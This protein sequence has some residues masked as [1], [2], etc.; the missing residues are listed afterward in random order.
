MASCSV[1]SR[2]V[3]RVRVYC[4][5]R[6][7]SPAA[8][9]RPD[10]V[11]RSQGRRTSGHTPPRGRA[12]WRGGRSNPSRAGHG[13]AVGTR[14]RAPYDRH[15]LATRR[16]TEVGTARPASLDP[17]ARIRRPLLHRVPP[18]LD[19]MTALRQRVPTMG[20]N[21]NGPPPAWPAT[22][23]SHS[24]TEAPKRSEA[25]DGFRQYPPAHAIRPRTQRLRWLRGLD[26]LTQCAPGRIRTCAHG[27]GGRCSIP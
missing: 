5:R 16:L 14:T 8:P 21:Q 18:L 3:V 26:T 10:T 23:R 25:N 9:L 4:A 22:R 20:R 27:S 17:H 11:R 24:R 13:H 1:A 12:R 7:G 19:H 2:L 6:R 15:V